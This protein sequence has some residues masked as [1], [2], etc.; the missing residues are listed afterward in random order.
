[1]YFERDDLTLILL[2]E[3]LPNTVRN[4]ISPTQARKLLKEIETWEGNPKSQLKARADAH[5]SAIDGGNPFEYGKVAKELSRLKSR[6]E[7]R[8]RDRANLN[9]S[10]TLLTEELT[11]SLKKSSNQASELIHNAL[12]E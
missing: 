3:D 7:L 11:F 12:N 1:V 5:E 6:D 4:V 9:R 8:P 2:K 10:L